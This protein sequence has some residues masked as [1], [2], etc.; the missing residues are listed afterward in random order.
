MNTQTVRCED[1]GKEGTWIACLITLILFV[2]WV[3]L[4]YNQAFH[5]QSAL[6]ESQVSIKTLAPKQ[7]TMVADLRLAHEEIRNIY[8]DTDQWA[9]VE[10]LQQ[11]WLAPFVQDKSWIHQ[12]RYQ[13]TQVAKGIY[14]GVPAI[15]ASQQGDINGRFLLVSRAQEIVLWLD[16]KGSASLLISDVMGNAIPDA[17]AENETRLNQTLIDSGWRQVVFQND[18]KHQH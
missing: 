10:Q 15:K 5:E 7:L 16:T 1:G 2:G 8:L 12:G 6:V 11:T 13:W 17:I 18:E 3:L 9:T 4:P 14:Q